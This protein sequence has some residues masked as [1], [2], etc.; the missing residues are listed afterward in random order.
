MAE[1]SGSLRP[2]TVVMP[3]QALR[4][5]P[6]GDLRISPRLHTP[7]T[8]PLDEPINATAGCYDGRLAG[9]PL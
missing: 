9:A 6:E 1:R 2:C 3:L 7:P 5:R 4:E 8:Q